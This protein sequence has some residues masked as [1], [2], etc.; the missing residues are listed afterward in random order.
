MSGPGLAEVL[1]GYR[2]VELSHVLE[3]GMPRPQVPYG[4]IPWKSYERGDAFNTFMVLVFE[5]AGTHVDAPV[6]L[7]GVEGPGLD[8]IP[9][10]A[11]MGE[12][13]VLGFRGKGEG[14][15]VTVEEIREWEA[16]HGEIGEGA[17][18]LLDFGWAERWT[19]EHGVEDQPYHGDNPGLG[20]EA[21][22]YLADRGV[23]LVGGD[24][25]TIDVG[26]DPVEPA[27]RTLLPRGVLVLENAA[28][29]GEL[30]PRGAFFVGLP[31]RIRDGTGCPVRAV[32]FV[33]GI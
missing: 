28:N 24:V 4:H 26:S 19:T 14:E 11:W 7:G 12:L 20:E 25:P 31:M 15:T 13:A 9:A 23:K 29:L 10:E 5:H 1:K 17:V 16:I 27:H 8:G 6:H 2:V 30:P 21:A 32:A 33:P 18:V 3:E 22:A